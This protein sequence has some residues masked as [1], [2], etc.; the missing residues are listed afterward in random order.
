MG[1]LILEF[2]LLVYGRF[3]CAGHGVVL[4]AALAMAG[5][6]SIHRSNVRKNL[7]AWRMS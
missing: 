5:E 1:I 7:K 3:F 4:L 2:L 6:A